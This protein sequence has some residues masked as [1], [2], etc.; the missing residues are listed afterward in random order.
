MATVLI[1]GGTGLIGSALTKALIAK[2]YK[3]IILT[4]SLKAK[5]S[6][7]DIS[8]AQWNVKEQTIDTNA[9]ENANHIVHLAGANVGEKRWTEDRKREIVESRIMSSALIVK[10]LRE[11]SN[12]VK[13]VTSAS[14]IGW[15]GED[16]KLFEAGLRNE[17]VVP[18]NEN[19]PADEGFLGQTCKQW[20]ESIE[21]V[22]DMGIR[23]VK[24]RNGLVLSNEGGYYKELK[25]PMKF[26]LAAILGN[27]KQVVSWIHIDD[28][29]RLYIATIEDDKWEGVYN[30]V[31][32]DPVKHKAL[33]MTIVRAR[34]KFS[35]RFR[36]PPPVLKRVIG[37][38]A[39][40]A[41]KSTTVLPAK[42]QSSG[43]VFEYPTIEQAILALEGK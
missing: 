18:F 22:S 14:G 24:L 8:Y 38:G 1:T 11:I 25:K 3:V 4:R 10:A 19:D 6:T 9:I 43:F 29:V 31:T 32:P 23:L 37:E 20:E 35:F 30:A 27:G 41:L 17:T 33:V 36:V 26:G 5:K 21:P 12:D 16:K 34:R 15:Y 13:S 7:L 39:I 40:E 2:N 42:V 28:I